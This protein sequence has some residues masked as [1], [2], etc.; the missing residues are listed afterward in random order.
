MPGAGHGRPDPRVLG[1]G[2]QRDSE[3]PGHGAVIVPPK[4]SRRK[5]PGAGCRSPTGQGA[6]NRSTGFRGV[7][8]SLAPTGT[9]QCRIFILLVA[10]STLE[11]LGRRWQALAAVVTAPARAC[12]FSFWSGKDWRS[13]LRCA[14][15]CC[16]WPAWPTPTIPPPE[17]SSRSSS[18]RSRADPKPPI[19]LP[20]VDAPDRRR[21]GPGS[22]PDE[23]ARRSPGPGSVTDGPVADETTVA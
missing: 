2:E 16:T 8:L 14:S 13:W 20:V 10:R 17:S 22:L 21:P 6:R 4:R 23:T 3:Q 9:F 12:R 1:T 19:H 5:A 18:P 11:C 15:T 7:R